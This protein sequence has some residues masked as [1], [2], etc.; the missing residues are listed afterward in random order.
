MRDDNSLGFRL[1]KGAAYVFLAVV[2]GPVLLLT[3]LHILDP[4]AWG[5][6]RYFR[7]GR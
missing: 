6:E 7:R 3:K 4:E 2:S 5:T 1:V